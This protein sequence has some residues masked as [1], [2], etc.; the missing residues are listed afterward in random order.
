MLFFFTFKFGESIYPDPWRML[1]TLL[2]KMRN[3]HNL[4]TPFSLSLAVTKAYIVNNFLY[5]NL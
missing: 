4:D 5:D 3:T 1:F 2:K